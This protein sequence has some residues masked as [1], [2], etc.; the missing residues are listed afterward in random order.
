MAFRPSLRSLW[1]LIA[2]AVICYGLFLWA[3]YSKVEVQRDNYEVKLIAANRMNAALKEL[4]EQGSDDETLESYGDPRLDAIIGQQFSTITTDIA[5]FEEKMAGAN[6]NLAAAV[7]ELLIDAGLKKG[8]VVAVAMTGSNPGA[9]LA[10]LCACDA[11]GVEP[12][13]ISALSSTWWGAN[14]P[15]DTWAD[16]Q[17]KLQKSG[18]LTEKTVAY[19]R[20][21][22]DDNALGLSSVGRSE[23]AAAAERNGARLLET[24]S[25][26]Q[27]S[28]AW[29]TAFKSAAGNKK[30]AAY[31]NVGEGVASLGHKENLGLLSNGVYTALPARNWPARGAMHMA[32]QEGIKVIQ[33]A[34]AANLSEAYGLG[35]PSIPLAD[36][37]KG[38][39]FTTTRY[40]IRVAL[41]ALLL[42][43][44]ALF[45]LVW[46]DARYFRLADA[47]VDPETLL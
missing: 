20:G 9:N 4:A 6:P 13:T 7:L 14:D 35:A 15:R 3:E 18:L 25:I 36:P 38:D 22:L 19:S 1:T 30:V 8:D 32:S 39:V 24:T 27:A 23:L 28:L 41:V 40:D 17:T 47:G 46:F 26:S 34:S 10:V 45:T 42:S 5:S 29:W 12:L 37:G 16:M 2:M 44:G 43:L 11:L 31:I 21:G 33:I